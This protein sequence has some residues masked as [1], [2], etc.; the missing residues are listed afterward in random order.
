[1]STQEERPAHLAKKRNELARTDEG[2][3]GPRSFFGQKTSLYMHT[4]IFRP[5]K[6]NTTE[7][8][9]ISQYSN[10]TSTDGQH[11]LGGLR[12]WPINQKEDTEVPPN[13]DEIRQS[14]LERR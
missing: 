11:S 2:R 1:L 6:K 7:S 14:A 9:K 10:S 3:S 12:K 8:K 13:A 4:D 5:Q